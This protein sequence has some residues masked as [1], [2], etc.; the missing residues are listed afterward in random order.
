MDFAFTKPN[1]SGAFHGAPE[2][3]RQSLPRLSGSLGILRTL[4]V[5]LSL[6]LPAEGITFRWATSSQRI[7]VSGPGS[8]TLS[9]IKAA[10]PTAPL[11]L[12]DPT[13]LIWH[14]G[15]D[16]FVET[17]AQLKIYGTNNGGDVN[18][19]RLK[20]E[21]TFDPYAVVEIRADWGWL[22]I[23]STK[24]ISWDSAVEGPD[25][26][27]L[28]YGR[29]FLRARS[30]LDPDGVTAH[31]S[32]LDVIDSDVGYLG[33]Q[34][35]EAYGLTWKVVDTTAQH[36]PPD[37]TNT[38]FDLVNVYGDIINS[39]LH[40]NWFGMYSYGHQGGVWSGNEVDHNVRYGF[41][42]HDDSDD[43][44]IES[45]NIH[46]NGWHGLIASKRCDNLVIRSNTV[47]ANGKNGIMLHRHCNNS[48]IEDNQSHSNVDSGI[49][50]FDTDRTLIR[51]NVCLSNANAGIRF[52][53]GAKDNQVEGN[54]FGFNGRNGIYLYAG[55]DPPESDDEDPT[56]S[57]RC[58]GNTFTNNFVHNY[59]AEA[60]KVSNG[61]NNFFVANIFSAATN[62]LRLDSATNTVFI[63][64]TLPINTLLKA[65][66]S[67]TNET[68][69][70]VMDQPQLDLQ[71]DEYSLATFADFNG[72]VFAIFDFV[73]DNFPTTVMATGS[74]ATVTLTDLE[75]TTTVLTRNLFLAPDAGSVF[76][77]PTTW[78]LTGDLEK[79][80]TAY[81]SNGTASIACIVGDLT[82]GNYYA[83]VAGTPAVALGTYMAS[84]QGEINFA[85]SSL[86]LPL[87]DT[88]T[89]TVSPTNIPLNMPPMLLALTNAAV[90]ELATLTVTNTATDDNLPTN[91]LTYAL[92]VAPSGAVI[93]TNGVIIWTPDETQGPGTN[94]IT[95]IVT[96]G[97]LSATNSFT[98]TV[99]ETNS[100]PT[101]L[102]LMDVEIVELTTLTVTNMASDTDFPASALT[103]A[104][105]DAPMGAVIDVNGVITWTP[106]GSQGPSTNLIIT[107]ATDSELSAT[108]TFTVIVTS[109]APVLLTIQV[110]APDLA[111]LSWPATSPGW[112]LQET[113]S[114]VT[115]NWTNTITGGSALTTG[116]GTNQVIVSPRDGNKF[117]R[118]FH[119]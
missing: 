71:L 34:N 76:V 15:A 88:N 97:E 20:S 16:L 117:F 60:L 37:S 38:L 50:I 30:T 92:L 100:A 91:V 49:A 77:T 54:E 103:Y 28:V 36:L 95:T 80:W 93:D 19:L 21:N 25:T 44:V 114:L 13:N 61:D 8:A 65:I 99:T 26:E 2:S 79:A 83:V 55:S 107:V 119:P 41:D 33:S 6:A 7:Y 48:L 74:V 51:N 104:L 90:I 10:L 73:G 69:V 89:F 53:V 45:N 78:E 113:E 1:R 94:V 27:M 85:V 118:L 105:L 52:S 9:D 82:P 14:L 4:A 116:G 66:G 108:N 70:L 84:A 62:T 72:A 11:T 56:L 22:D 3:P 98:V 102:P 40:H 59:G 96:D 67:P 17:N 42:P 58:R 111:I 29:A 39:R 18:E 106:D 23:R 112:V 35:T 115:S 75:A 47:W 57:N 24:I 31:E 109:V 32:R 63:G 64:N 86:Q 81:A 5:L 43:L 110:I 68:S 12:V 87:S 101:L 46:D